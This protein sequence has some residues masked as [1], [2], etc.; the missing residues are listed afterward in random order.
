MTIEKKGYGEFMGMMLALAEI[1]V[2]YHWFK[3]LG[4]GVFQAIRGEF[5]T[6]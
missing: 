1:M 2:L 3:R 6:Q 4:N 5:A